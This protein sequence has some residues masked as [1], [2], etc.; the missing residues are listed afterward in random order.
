[1]PSSRK[2]LSRESARQSYL[3]KMALGIDF[4]TVLL[5]DHLLQT[6]LLAGMGAAFTFL[7]TKKLNR[8]E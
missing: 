7:G 3:R 2:A 5:F 8:L 4:F 6:I 1:M